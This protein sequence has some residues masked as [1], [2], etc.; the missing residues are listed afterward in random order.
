MSGHIAPVRL[1]FVIFGA[2][3]VFTL[4]TVWVSY[5]DLG[6]FNLT[7]AL[8]IAITK[9]MLVVLYFMHVR[10]SERLIQVTAASGFVFLLILFSITLSDYLT[11]NML[12]LGK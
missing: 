10:W 8:I 4:L 11:R 7:V 6:Y 1:Y 9:A 5:V 2:L 12:A 3:M